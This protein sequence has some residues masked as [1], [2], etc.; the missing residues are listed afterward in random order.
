MTDFAKKT[1]TKKTR[2]IKNNLEQRSGLRPKKSGSSNK[3]KTLA[4]LF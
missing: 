2:K 4:E 1:I 3:G